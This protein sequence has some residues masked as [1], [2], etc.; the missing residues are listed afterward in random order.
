MA[1]SK[2][3]V[4]VRHARIRHDGLELEISAIVG[5]PSRG[6]ITVAQADDMIFGYALLNDGSARDIQATFWAPARCRARYT[7]QKSTAGA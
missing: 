7:M 3:R 6:M 4:R 5:Q 2:H 1:T